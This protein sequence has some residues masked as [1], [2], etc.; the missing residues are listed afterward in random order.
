MMADETARRA[1]VKA[2][3]YITKDKKGPLKHTEIALVVDKVE[4]LLISKSN[5]QDLMK[6]LKKVLRKVGL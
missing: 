6:D 3:A 2:T 1:E 4:S 5:A